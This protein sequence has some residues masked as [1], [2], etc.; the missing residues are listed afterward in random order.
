M[1]SA[2]ETVANDLKSVDIGSSLH[3]NKGETVKR[4][5]SGPEPI[6]VPIILK[7]ADFDHK[8]LLEEWISTRSCEKYP[9]K[10]KDKLLS[11]LKT[12][13]DY[14]CSFK[15]QGLTV[16]NISATTFPQTLD[17]LHNYLLQCIEQGTSS[18]SSGNCGQTEGN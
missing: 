17:W 16:V 9:I 5:K 3:D 7:M 8:A 12:I 13:Q 11:N 15:S 18:V 1:L 2:V 4:E 6:I 14:L 10:D